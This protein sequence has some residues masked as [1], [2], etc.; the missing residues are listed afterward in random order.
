MKGATV[1]KP[2]QSLGVWL[3]RIVIWVVLVLSLGPLLYV[4][5][6]SFNSSQ[7]FF[8]AS[9][10]P[11]HFSFNNYKTVFQSSFFLWI[12]NSTEVALTVSIA[13]LLMTATAAYAFSRLK[14]FGRK[15]G[16][17]TLLL[18]QMFPNSMAIAAIYA[19]LAQ[20]GL[21][22]NLWVYILLLIGGSAFNIWLM[23]GY[24]DTIPRE[25]DEAAIMDGAGHLQIFWRIVLPLS[26]PMLAVIFFLTMIGLYSEYILA[27]TVLQSAQNY[28]L[29]LGMYTL[30]N[31]EFAQNWGE[32][33]AASLIAAIP[34]TLAFAFL[35]PIMAKGLT[36]GATKG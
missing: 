23:K 24:F 6:A 13:Q 9:L 2:G 5:G 28:T 26:R 11:A 21:L 34:L 20:W 36:A 35:N 1:R 27:G 14:F 16:L 19:M 3:S 12:R 33:A 18:L 31:G 22:D 25:L 10:I 7:S 4:I 30:I 17:M 8:S 32:F 29:G 15:Y